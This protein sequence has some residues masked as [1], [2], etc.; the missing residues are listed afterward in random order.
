MTKVGSPVGLVRYATQAEI[1][2]EPTHVIRPR[3]VVYSVLLLSLL[4]GFAYAVTHR[5]PVDLDVLRDRSSLYRELDDGRIE[6]VFTVR[7]INKDQHA[8]T[9]RLTPV[10][11]ANAVIDAESPTQTVDAED[12][13][14]VVV[15]V[16]TPSAQ[17]H[18]GQ[19]FVISAQALDDRKLIATSRARFFSKP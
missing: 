7:I 14:S 13:K 17:R 5:M 11:L 18:G 15:R 2:G 1:E 9:F 3:I 6:N 16:R 10:N 4:S 12:V 19:D 8:H